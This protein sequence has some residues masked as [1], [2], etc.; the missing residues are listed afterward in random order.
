MSSRQV[1]VIDDVRT[2]VDPSATHLRN[3]HEALAW[4]AAHEGQIDELWLDHDLGGEDTVRPVVAWLE[5]RVAT[6]TAP[7]IAVIYVHTANPVGA[8]YI[9]TSR[10]LGERYRMVRTDL[11]A[12]ASPQ[13]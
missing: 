8:Q 12:F 9:L 7:D 6:G 13:R 5:E 1:V 2:H 11:A 4:L 10:L 3:S